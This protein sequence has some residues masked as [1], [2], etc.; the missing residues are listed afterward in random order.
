MTLRIHDKV[1]TLDF[2][3]VIPAGPL[4][5]VNAKAEGQQ[6]TIDVNW[7]KP[8]GNLTGFKVTCLLQGGRIED[9]ITRTSTIQ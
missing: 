2:I 9:K 3:C 8:E 5:V 7:E 6:S 1:L 4:P